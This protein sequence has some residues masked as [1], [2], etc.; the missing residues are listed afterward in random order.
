MVP[1]DG[2]GALL[3]PHSAAIFV[4]KSD[5]AFPRFPFLH[6]VS[7]TLVVGSLVVFLFLAFYTVVSHNGRDL[8]NSGKNVIN[9]YIT[10]SGLISVFTF[11]MFSIFIECNYDKKAN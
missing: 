1:G 10:F 5:F 11:N 2:F 3:L 4:T 9:S 6:A 7:L 8:Y